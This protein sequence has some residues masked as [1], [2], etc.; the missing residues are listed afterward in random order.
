LWT[1]GC[2]QGSLV[3]AGGEEA[4]APWP[5]GVQILTNFS[6]LLIAINSAVN[7]IVYAIKV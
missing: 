2:A 1:L 4:V 5:P 6:H 3:A 7:I